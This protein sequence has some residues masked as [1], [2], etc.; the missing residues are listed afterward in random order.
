[1]FGSSNNI[2]PCLYF[3]SPNLPLSSLVSDE[4]NILPVRG[5]TDGEIVISLLEV[6]R[7]LSSVF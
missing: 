3:A 1:V 5:L 4:C 2:A 6:E 7:D